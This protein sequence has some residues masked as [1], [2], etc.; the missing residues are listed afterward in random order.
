MSDELFWTLIFIILLLGVVGMIAAY[1]LA[2]IGEWIIKK[3][4]EKRNE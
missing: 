3:V 1:A 4:K 2:A